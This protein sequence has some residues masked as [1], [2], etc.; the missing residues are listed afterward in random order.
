MMR[1]RYC[2]TPII[3]CRDFPVLQIIRCKDPPVL[4]VVSLASSATEGKKTDNTVSPELFYYGE[5]GIFQKLW[6]FCV[7][8]VLDTHF[9][10]F[11]FFFY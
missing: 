4:S 3:W 1:F 8:F 6:L 5:N 9:N 11:S 10:C 7:Y 2:H